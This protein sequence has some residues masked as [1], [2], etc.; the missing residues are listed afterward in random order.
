M[1]GIAGIYRFDG[2]SVAADT[3]AAMTEAIDHRGPDGE[4]TWR[5]GRVGL[6]HQRFETTPEAEHA[7]SPP[8]RDGHVLTFDGRIDNREEL[9]STLDVAGP[10]GRV[11]DADLVL[12]AYERWG[13][14]CPERLIGAFAFA[15]RDPDEERLFA[16]RDHVGLRPFYYYRGEDCFLF[17]S[18]LKALWAVG[19]VPRRL[20]E[21][22]LSN[23]LAQEYQSDER[24]Y[25]E[26]AYR[27]LADRPELDVPEVS[28][29]HSKRG[30][31]GQ[32]TRRWR[33]SG[34]SIE[35]LT[36]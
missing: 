22:R 9:L 6:G 15:I 36:S 16:A 21:I 28:R 33:W 31:S 2:G 30:P 3:V 24:T 7:G 26:A 11:A 32:L 20:D 10:P 5:E 34:H 19:G 12:A 27:W 23:H 4:W 17:G 29:L 8:E 35:S 14:D 1:S 13:E 25:F 18:E